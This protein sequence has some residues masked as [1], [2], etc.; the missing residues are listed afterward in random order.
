MDLFGVVRLAKPTQ[1]TV[2]VLPLRDGEEPVLQATAGRTMVIAQEEGS[3]DVPPVVM[4]AHPIR[5]IPSAASHVHMV[6]LSETNSS[7]SAEA[8]NTENEP[9]SA[10][11]GTKRNQV[12]GDA[13]VGKSNRRRPL[14]SDEQSSSQEDVSRS[15][16]VEDTSSPK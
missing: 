6:E 13:G 11:Q 8:P 14:F 2:G 9:E 16:L 7:E 1:V 5:S 4:E 12:D 10:S 3:E 15:L